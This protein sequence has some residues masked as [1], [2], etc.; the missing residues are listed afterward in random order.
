MLAT[1]LGPAAGGAKGFNERKEKNV[2]QSRGYVELHLVVPLQML[3]VSDV[4]PTNVT[5]ADN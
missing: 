2:G 3:N 1:H 5:L 4:S